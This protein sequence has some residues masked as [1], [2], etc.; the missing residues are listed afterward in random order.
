MNGSTAEIIKQT[1][2]IVSFHKDFN[3]YAGKGNPGR[4]DSESPG[5]RSFFPKKPWSKCSERPK[6]RPL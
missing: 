1:N 6:M 5:R 3:P 4:S 2:S